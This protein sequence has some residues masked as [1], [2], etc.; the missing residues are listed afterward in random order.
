MVSSHP[1]AYLEPS[2]LTHPSSQSL[3]IVP[4]NTNPSTFTHTSHTSSAPSA[5]GIHDTLRH[6]LGPSPYDNTTASTVPSS[7]HPLESRLKNWEAT[8]DAMRMETLRR[9]YGLAEPVR[10]GMELS[11]V[12][13]GEWKPAAMGSGGLPSLHEEILRGKEDMIS[14]E[15]VFTG[16]EM[17]SAPQFHDEMERKVKMQK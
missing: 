1:D 10:R 3:R 2:S 12:R 11:I 17:R 9:T 4:S 15:D 16:E 7:S 13:R 6:G 8:Q 14:W 5:P